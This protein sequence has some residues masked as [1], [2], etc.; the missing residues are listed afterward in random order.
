MTF[1]TNL[2]K[3]KLG[4]TLV[5][6]NASLFLGYRFCYT[7][8][9]LS[10]SSH[11]QSSTSYEFKKNNMIGNELPIKNGRMG[12]M[13]HN[14][15]S[16]YHNEHKSITDNIRTNYEKYKNLL[17]YHKLN[18]SSVSSTTL[19]TEHIDI[20][21]NYGIYNFLNELSKDYYNDTD[22][23]KIYELLG[24][25]DLDTL[26]ESIPETYYYEFSF[27][28]SV[29]NDKSMDE[30]R[31]KIRAEIMSRE[32]YFEKINKYHPYYIN[33]IN[34]KN[35]ELYSKYLYKSNFGKQILIDNFDIHP[36]DTQLSIAKLFLEDYEYDITKI[37]NDPFLSKIVLDKTFIQE[38]VKKFKD[39]IYLDYVSDII[40]EID[41]S[42]KDYLINKRIY[43]Y[44]INEENIKFNYYKPIY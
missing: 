17:I 6:G 3:H 14:N 21:K 4:K 37:K 43:Q 26:L 5:I 8:F 24:Q 11:C 34:A 29:Y 15:N 36:I 42:I 12:K 7:S 10:K 28:S 32:K 9:D 23:D 1:S 25:H 38:Y 44:Q 2:F 22:T 19:N 39:E 40:N 35:Y 27:I 30:N 41:P 16:Y 18:D 20:I 33:N 31:I 13:S